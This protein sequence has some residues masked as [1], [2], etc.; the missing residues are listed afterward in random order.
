MRVLDWRGDDV[1]I[2]VASTSDFSTCGALGPQRVEA[3]A[4]VEPEGTIGSVGFVSQGPINPIAASCAEE[5][6]YKVRTFDGR[7]NVVL[8]T[9]FPL[10]VA[11]QRTN[12]ADWSRRPS[13]RAHRR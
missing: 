8:R 5:R 1:A 9:V 4:Y 6:M 3:I 10:V 13:K 7:P 12:K 11:A 2:R